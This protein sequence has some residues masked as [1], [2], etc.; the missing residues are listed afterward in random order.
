MKPSLVYKQQVSYW[1]KVFTLYAITEAVIQLLYFII[2]N[3]FGAFRISIIEYHFIMWCFQ[4]LLIWPIWWVAKLVTKKHVAVQILVN[5]AFYTLYSYLWFGPV[6]DAIEY[7]YN[8]LQQVTR[9]VTDRQ[10]AYLDRGN[11]YSFLNYQLLKHCFRL[12]WF[13][14]AA[15]FYNYRNSEKQRME[16]AVANK[17]L[18][19]KMLTW[20]LNPSFYFKAINYLKQVAAKKPMNA[21]ESILQ[22]S[23]VMEYVIYETKEKL[24]YVEKEITFLDNY[25]QLLNRQPD[26][27]IHIT[28]SIQGE[29]AHLKIAPLLL[30]GLVDSISESEKRQYRMNLKF[31]ENGMLIL[32][33]KSDKGKIIL[34][35]DSPA[36][37]RLNELYVGRFSFL[38]QDNGSI[39]QL[40]L[41]L[42]EQ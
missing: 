26:N 38:V 27:N 11:E 15:Y 6:Q 42:D 35:Y 28:L 36:L 37:K 17:E 7:L 25:F 18:Q 23:K 30:T 12:S 19:L 1:F 21:A 22:L 39:A 29:Y 10:V 2:L 9:P 40:N 8:N 14:L 33:E 16:L 24:I 4:C 32:L 13:Y 3:N 34:D 5:L 31:S 41:K 20:H